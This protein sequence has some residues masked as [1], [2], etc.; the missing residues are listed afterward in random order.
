MKVK[1]VVEKIKK[2]IF[3]RTENKILTVFMVVPNADAANASN[4]QPAV[5]TQLQLGAL[6][7][8]SS[9]FGF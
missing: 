5:C 9:A 4:L 1:P 2:K 3:Q 6:I 7:I 8:T